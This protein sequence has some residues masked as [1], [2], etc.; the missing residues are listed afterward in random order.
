MN[1]EKVVPQDDLVEEE[2]RYWADLRELQKKFA[3]AGGFTNNLA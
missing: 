1:L 3:E 2:L